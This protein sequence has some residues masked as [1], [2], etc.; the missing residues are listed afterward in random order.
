MRALTSKE[1]KL[2]FVLVGALFLLLNVFALKTFLGRRAL[3]QSNISSLEGQLIQDR[4]LL[5]QRG[6]WAER[7]QWLDNN[8]QAEDPGT[9]DDENRF[10]EFVESSAKKHGLSYSR[11]GG[12][13]VF[14]D[15]GS[16]A[17]VYDASQVKG[18]MKS[19]VAWL[20][21]L[22]QPEAFRA[23]KQLRIKSGEPPEVVCDVEVALW[24]RP[25]GG[26]SP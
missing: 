2:L 10:I 17:E 20:S 3:L 26:T 19:L 13:S 11:K 21:E 12:E 24:R 15:G 18:N 7:A 22:Q 4:A 14:P 16:F 5:G 23:I 1:K 8:M 25:E 9:V 6:Y